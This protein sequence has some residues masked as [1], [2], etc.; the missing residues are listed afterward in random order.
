MRKATNSGQNLICR[1]KKILSRHSEF[2]GDTSLKE[3]KIVFS[4]YQVQFTPL[5]FRNVTLLMEKI[6]V[7]RL[8]IIDN[9][10]T[11]LCVKEKK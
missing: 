4:V 11:Y 9:K 10:I 1:Q 8:R 3:K 6:N 5:S 7:F 2:E